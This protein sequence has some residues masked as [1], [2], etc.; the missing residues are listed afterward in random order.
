MLKGGDT[1]RVVRFGDVGV[2]GQDSVCVALA[3]PPLPRREIAFVV[4]SNVKPQIKVL[5][6]LS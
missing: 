1:V 2:G 3:L 4:E 5:Y 6:I